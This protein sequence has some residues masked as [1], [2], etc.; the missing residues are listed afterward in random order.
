[1]LIRAELA[2]KAKCYARVGHY[3]RV[4]I[5]INF[6]TDILS[7]AYGGLDTWAACGKVERLAW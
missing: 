3:V 2:E 1:M 7:I 4:A 6:T 5:S